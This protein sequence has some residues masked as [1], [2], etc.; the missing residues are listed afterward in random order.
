M[1]L[2]EQ[3]NL[4]SGEKNIAALN[5]LICLKVSCVYQKNVM[6]TSKILVQ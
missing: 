6:C 1:P 4:R 3:N 2:I 5:P